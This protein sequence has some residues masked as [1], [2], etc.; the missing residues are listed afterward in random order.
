MDMIEPKANFP[1]ALPPPEG[2]INVIGAGFIARAVEMSRQSPRKR[3]IL[4]F[5][6]HHEDPLHRMLNAIQPS[7]Y[8]RPHRHKT[9]PKA[10]CIVVLRGAVR[11][12]AFRDSGEID[13]HR[14]LAVTS[15][16]IGVD[17]EPGVF[18]TYLALVPDTVLF[19][20]K[21]GP[22][23]PASAKDFAPWAP[24]EGS[25][26]ASAYLERLRALGSTP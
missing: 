6:K 23:E 2:N 22:Y 12:I 18:H 21:P 16:D 26:E 20:V 7:S 5:H 3:I 24:A 19:E 11:Y 14:V 13:L 17:T 15:P 4:P 1:V 8:I 9:P 10:E 25:P